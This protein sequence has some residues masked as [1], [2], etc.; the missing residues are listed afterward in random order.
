MDWRDK[1][2]VEIEDNRQEA[3]ELTWKRWFM[4]IMRIVLETKR[5]T[6]I[7]QIISWKKISKI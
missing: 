7:R 5:T 4:F 1:R 2:L 3:F 6:K